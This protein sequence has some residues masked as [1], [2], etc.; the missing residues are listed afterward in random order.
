MS[1]LS[2]SLAPKRVVLSSILYA[3]DL[4]Q[5]SIKAFP[6]ALSIASKYGS[7]LFGVHVIA[8]LPLEDTLQPLT[9]Q[10][11]SAQAAREARDGMALLEP[12]L[13]GIPHELMIRK[14]EIWDRL[15]EI[16]EKNG[17]DLIVA[18]THGRSGVSKLLMGSV[19]EKIFRHAACPVLIVGPNVSGEPRSIA[20]IHEILF[21][22]DFSAESLSALPY[23]ISLAQENQSRLYLMHVAR[24][25][26]NAFEEDLVKTRLLSLVSPDVKLW[27]EPKA[28][29]ESGD[30]AQKIMDIAEELGV[31]LIVLGTKRVPAITGAV[32]HLG[33]ATAYKV[34]SQSI[35]PILAVR[36]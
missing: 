18:G 31:D 22:T 11:I 24:D 3:T 29:V 26:M 19:A 5:D 8:S 33:M 16:I 14:G 6:Y 12:K 36:G 32:T 27:C 9:L 21:P 4:S 13:K 15:S 2:V 1:K 20:D 17:I 28:F 25:P 23:A 7:T 34:A 10:A 35:C 30:A